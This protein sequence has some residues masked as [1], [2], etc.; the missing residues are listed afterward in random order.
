MWQHQG[1]SPIVV[2]PWVY[3]R[4]DF[5]SFC[6]TIFETIEDVAQVTI[7]HEHEVAD[8]VSIGTSFNDLK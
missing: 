6:H 1:I 2:E 8:I 4:N 7:N 3:K 5:C